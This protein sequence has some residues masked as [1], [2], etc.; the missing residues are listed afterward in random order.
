MDLKVMAQVEKMAQAVEDVREE[1]DL[2]CEEGASLEDIEGAKTLA[3]DLLGRY[4]LLIEQLP[5]DE[6][7]QLERSVG[8]GMELIRGQFKKLKEAPE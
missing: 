1:I 7:L 6:R 2:A 3:A 4:A 5:P 8:P